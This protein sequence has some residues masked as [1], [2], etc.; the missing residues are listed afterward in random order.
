L[1]RG[2]RN[3]LVS[4]LLPVYNGERYVGAAVRSLV[5]QTY[6]NIEVLAL[7]DGSTDGSAAAVE[8]VVDAR[9]RL[10]RFTH[11]GLSSVLN[12]G[13]AAARGELIARQDADDMAEPERIARQVAAFDACSELALVGC[14]AWLMSTSGTIIGGVERC[15]EPATIRWY[16]L[17]DNPFIHTAVMFR[18]AAVRELGGY[19]ATYD[20]YSQDFALWS[21]LLER[22]PALNL[23]QRLVR[24]RISETS[25]TGAADAKPASSSARRFRTLVRE[26]AIANLAR[27]F[28]DRLTPDERSVLADFGGEI[29]STHVRQFF[30]AFT[31][32]Y[33][34]FVHDFPDCRTPDFH[35]TVA[36][37]I[38]AIAFRLAP[39]SRRAAVAVYARGL[40]L[41]P[42]AS[43]H[44]SW[45]RALTLAV[46]GRSARR[47]LSRRRTLAAP[48]AQAGG[49]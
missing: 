37:Q 46:L 20:P 26:I 22:A 25:I 38:D 10:L 32:L 48:A 27:A 36:R 33:R 24:Y 5:E 2:E 9:V 11:R 3:P 31:H 1:G 6:R 42:R 18:A 28:G 49:R 4:V 12:D 16:G 45:S 34:L 35:R 17:L 47:W 7:D 39:P 23:A 19:D 8:R 43:R 40:L 29:D 41:T 30:D 15:T 21:R 13:L 14:Q 44:V